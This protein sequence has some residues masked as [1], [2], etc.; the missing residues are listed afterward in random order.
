MAERRPTPGEML[1]FRRTIMAHF[2]RASR[3]MPWRYTHDPYQVLVS[4]VMLQ[5]TQVE[6]V[7]L[8]YGEFLRRF[9]DFRSLAHA[10]LREVLMT[11]QGLGYNR[12]A[13]ALRDAASIILQQHGGRLPSSIEELT[14][15]PGIGH[16][17]ASALLA[18]AFDLPAV[19]IETNIRR[20]LIHFFFHDQEDVPDSEI[21]P[22]VECALP[23][24][25]FRQW[26]YALMDYGAMLKK[27]VPNP[28]RRSRHYQ[29]QPRF[30]GSRRQ[31]RGKILKQIVESG[32]LT[33]ERLAKKISA[34]R[35]AVLSILADLGRD[36]L[37]KKT[38]RSY[39]IR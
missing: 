22:L 29:V 2:S 8:K 6:R 1:R 30:E 12:R 15:L 36:G 18:F 17:T 39:S 32:T 14:A 9:P 23:R 37:L 11:W 24:K 31:L 38:G 27:A 7:L 25:G 10:P 13:R 3:P 16:A 19:F 5:Q 26:Y 4:E 21:L 34:D 28:N 20:V 35:E 33:P